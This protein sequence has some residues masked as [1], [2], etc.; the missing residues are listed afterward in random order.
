MSEATVLDLET[1][2]RIGSAR[3][4]KSQQVQ[5]QVIRHLSEEDLPEILSPSS[6]GSKPPM[7]KELKAHHHQIARLLAEGTRPQDVIMIT[8][9]SS[10]RISILQDDPTF[11][12]LVEYY[13]VQKDAAYLDVHARLAGLGTQA[14]EELSLRL[15]DSPGSFSNKEL[16]DVMESTFDRSVA[17]AKGG[18]KALGPGPSAAVQV[19]VNFVKHDAPQELQFTKIEGPQ[20]D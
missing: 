17:P 4:R 12:D 18:P 8:G 14:M 1:L 7:L 11:I 6:V 5:A 20:D 3:G 9:M 15:E 16:K 19:V 10:S 13:R 2:A